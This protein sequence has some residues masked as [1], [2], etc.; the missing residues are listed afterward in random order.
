MTERA[1]C[2]IIGGGIIGAS[3]AYHL[4]RLDC[5]NIILLEK[6]YLASK[7]TGVCPGGIR[8]QWSTETACLY[9]R[10]SVRFFE[11]LSEELEPEFPLPFL[12][13]GY[14]FLAHQESTL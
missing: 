7:A 4:T 9:A 12:Q 11:N 8:Q 6:D 10:E 14:L 5:S 13:T 1:D 3:I 2:V